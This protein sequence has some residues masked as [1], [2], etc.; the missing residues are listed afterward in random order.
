MLKPI[1]DLPEGVIG[2]EATGKIRAS[3]FSDLLTPAVRKVW[4]QGKDVRIVLVFER[5]GGISAGA[6]WHDIKLGLEHLTRWERIALVTDLDWM[7]TATSLFGW[8]SPGK[9]KR[10]PV[11][12]RDAAIAWAANTGH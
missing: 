10:F 1:P 9:L 7:I 12:G 4:E 2:F 3:D 11:A 6:A 5:F 8:M